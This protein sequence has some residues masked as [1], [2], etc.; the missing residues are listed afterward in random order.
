VCANTGY[1]WDEVGRLTLPRL[2]ALMRYWEAHPPVHLLV[3][4]YLGYKAPGVGGVANR[5]AAAEISAMAAEAPSIKGAP[6]LDTSAWAN[7]KQG[8]PDG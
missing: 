5:E 7:R 4:S 2:K 6:R 1:T 3:A 8:A